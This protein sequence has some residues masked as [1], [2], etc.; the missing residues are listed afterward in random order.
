MTLVAEVKCEETD[1]T[2]ENMNAMTLTEK[3]VMDDPKNVK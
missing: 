2:L 3:T 1:L